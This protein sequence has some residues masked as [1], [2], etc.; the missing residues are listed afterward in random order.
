MFGLTL[1]LVSCFECTYCHC[2]RNSVATIQFI[3]CFF[4][5][6]RAHNVGSRAR[7][8]IAGLQICV[9][10][11]YFIPELNFLRLFYG[12]PVNLLFG[13]QQFSFWPHFDLSQLSCIIF[14][15]FLVFGLEEK[16]IVFIHPNAQCEWNNETTVSW[17]SACCDCV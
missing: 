6:C 17:T 10:T 13:E 8:M 16:G 9:H 1:Y 14:F 11:I 2:Q 3:C 7:T 5:V 4:C 15:S 12:F